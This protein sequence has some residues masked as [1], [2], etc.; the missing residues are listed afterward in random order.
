M[1]DQYKANRKEM[2]EDLSKQ[3]PALFRL[4][5]VMGIKLHKQPG[6]EADDIIGS[7]SKLWTQ[8]DLETYIVSG[9]KDL[10]QLV[11]ENTILYAPKKAGES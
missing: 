9:D 6:F 1:Y 2:P 10:M 11:T 3:L 7:M 4:M 5:E 8:K